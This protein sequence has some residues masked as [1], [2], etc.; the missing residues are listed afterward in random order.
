MGASRGLGRAIAAALARE[1][2]R[3][4]I[5]S[6]SPEKLEEA[7]AE[8]GDAAMPFV[9]TLKTLSRAGMTF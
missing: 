4:A 9:P 6:R 1:G 8:I 3:V 2:A 5:V 7:V